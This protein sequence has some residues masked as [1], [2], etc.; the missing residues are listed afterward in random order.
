VVL[1]KL[2]IF[3]VDFA[4]KKKSRKCKWKV[5]ATSQTKLKLSMMDTESH[6]L[7]AMDDGEQMKP[8]MKDFSP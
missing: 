8:K 2:S 1:D 3:G 6:V 4:L 5:T 7:H